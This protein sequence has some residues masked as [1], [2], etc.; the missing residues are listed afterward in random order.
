MTSKLLG[1]QE[2]HSVGI[3]G[4]ALQALAMNRQTLFFFRYNIT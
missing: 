3:V 4:H 2:S 1:L